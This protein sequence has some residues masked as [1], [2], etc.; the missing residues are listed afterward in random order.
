GSTI[1]IKNL[2]K[3]LLPKFI[4]SFENYIKSNFENNFKNLFTEQKILDK[5]RLKLIN[6]LE[7]RV[8]ELRFSSFEVGLAQDTTMLDIENKKVRE[9]AVNASDDY[10]QEILEADYNNPETV[11]L[12]MKNYTLEQRKK[13][14]GPLN[15]LSSNKEVIFTYKKDKTSKYIKSGVKSQ[16]IKDKILREEKP[17]INTPEE[18]NYEFVNVTLLVEKGKTPKKINT[19]NGLF[20]SSNNETVMLT[21]EIFKNHGC[22]L[23]KNINL[24]LKAEVQ[25]DLVHYSTVFE[26]EDFQHT[27]KAGAN[28]DAGITAII[29]KIHEYILNTK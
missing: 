6:R 18:K 9:W 24:E 19:D 29:K 21:S 23:E 25:G 16:I 14:L 5:I 3:Q 20:T 1:G 4:S 28:F 12:L 7:P 15:E 26:Y 2:T 8:V 13:I 11:N 17:A 22:P 10:K 27:E